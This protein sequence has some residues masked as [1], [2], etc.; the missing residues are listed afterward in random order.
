MPEK[1]RAARIT[2]AGSSVGYLVLGFADLMCTTK[3]WVFA[4]GLAA[5]PGVALLLVFF[6]SPLVKVLLF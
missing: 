2:I 4:G 6:P 3:T 5:W 1:A